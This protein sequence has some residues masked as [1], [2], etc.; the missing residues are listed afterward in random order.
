MGA[1]GVIYQILATSMVFGDGHDEYM[2]GD[3]CTIRAG[4]RQKHIDIN[5]HNIH[6]YRWLL[7]QS[8]LVIHELL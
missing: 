4:I 3:G 5:N 1:I 2:H 6:N 8:T 7:L